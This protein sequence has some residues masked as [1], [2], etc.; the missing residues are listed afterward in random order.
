MLFAGVSLSCHSSKAVVSNESND[1]II[2]DG[3]SYKTAVVIQEKTET[4]GVHAE[5]QWIR[6]HY[7]NYKV[8]SQA[9]RVIEKKPFD[10]ISI[11]FADGGKQDV[12]FDISKFL[13]HL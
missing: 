9:L 13:G 3:K 12:Y 5:Y 1:S 10:V 7:S 6:D 4:P 11:E 2:A 8:T